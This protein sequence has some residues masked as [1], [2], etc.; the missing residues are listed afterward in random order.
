MGWQNTEILLPQEAT[1]K[2]RLANTDSAAAGISS[3]LVMVLV[4]KFLP[5]PAIRMEASAAK[6]LQA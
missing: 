3:F 5:P 2:G 1:V 4:E 6:T